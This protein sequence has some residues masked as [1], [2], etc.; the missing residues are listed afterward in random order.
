MNPPNPQPKRAARKW[1]QP[2]H[3][4]T[5]WNQILKEIDTST[6]PT[7]L[8]KEIVFDMNGH[9][10][11]YHM[12]DVQTDDLGPLICV[13]SQFKDNVTL[14]VDTVLMSKWIDRIVQPLLQHIPSG[15]KQ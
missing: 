9:P 1:R 12:K 8:V 6:V 2:K 7:A 11:R 4:G 14:V 5:D 3:V 15:I 13:R 10:L